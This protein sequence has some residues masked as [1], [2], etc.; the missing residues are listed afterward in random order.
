MMREVDLLI[1]DD[2]GTQNPTPWTGEKLFQLINHRYN[3]H[4]DTIITTNLSLDDMENRISSRLH[5]SHY[6]RYVNMDQV[7]DYRYYASADV[8]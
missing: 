5:D 3:N 6:S 7:D 1:L 2:L 8:D 4:L